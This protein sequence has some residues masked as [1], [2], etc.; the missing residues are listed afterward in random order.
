M[1]KKVI[2]KKTQIDNLG[3]EIR[4]LYVA[5]TRAKE[6]LIMTGYLKKPEDLYIEKDFSF[7]ELMSVKSYLELV[8]PAMNN[9]FDDSMKI[10]L[11]GKEEI[12]S[13]EMAKQV[14]LSQDLADIR[15]NIDSGLRDENIQKLI[16]DRL[17][18]TYPYSD[19]A[20]L[21]VKLS[22]SELKKMGQFIDDEDSDKLY[23]EQADNKIYTM[24]ESK[25]RSS[26]DLSSN[27]LGRSEK[28]TSEDTESIDFDKTGSKDIESKDFDKTVSED[29]E[30]IEINNGVVS[31]KDTGMV[32]SRDQYIPEFIKGTEE[33]ISGTDR[34]TIYHK[35][36]ELLKPNKVNNI[37][38]LKSQLHDMVLQGQITKDDIARLNLK[39]IY[40]F[41]QSNVAKRLS[42]AEKEGKLY[43]EKQF[44]IGLPT[45]DVYPD[46]NSEEL[47]LIQGIIDVFFE[48][49]G[50]LVLLDYKSDIVQ[51][52]D[53]LIDRYKVQLIYYKKAL[54]Q[55]LGKKVKE[56]IIYSLYLGKEIV[57]K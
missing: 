48:E 2:Q 33:E 13:S 11:I 43:K 54:E 51:H 26:E 16:R 36:L 10:R 29:M 8:L 30:D 19:E 15:R 49:E 3:E 50:E 40:T 12:I 53:Q 47:I 1:L 39:N 28:V 9:R 38:D 22:V 32:V 14:F 37:D 44:V 31:D 35:V 57:V 42:E 18:F 41:T 55:I 56:M 45:S 21:R 23:E 46:K 24:A 25:D 5:M 52:E 6:K 34:G 4:V 27:D 17:S 7:F 20:Q